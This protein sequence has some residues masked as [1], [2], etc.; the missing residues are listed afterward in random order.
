MPAEVLGL[1]NLLK[2]VDCRCMYQALSATSASATSASTQDALQLPA[3][4]I[5]NNSGAAIVLVMLIPIRHAG[6]HAAELTGTAASSCQ[7]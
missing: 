4:Q 7:L 3:A 1:Y 6:L 2:L 5:V